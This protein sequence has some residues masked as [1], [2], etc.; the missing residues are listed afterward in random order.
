MLGLRQH[1]I[2]VVTACFLFAQAT[3]AR[4]QRAAENAI[5]A[6]Q[7]AFGTSVGNERIG[8]YSES[9]VRGFSPIAAGN[10]RIEGL[11][12]DRQTT[13]TARLIGGS[14]IR[15]GLTSQSY[16][17]TAPTGVVDYRLRPVG[18]E[19]NVSGYAAVGPHSGRQFDLDVQLPIAGDLLAVGLGATTLRQEPIPGDTS[20]ITSLAFLTRWTPSEN[21]E[22]RVALR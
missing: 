14:S 17:F 12:F 8:L 22:I 19:V 16:P 21:L 20:D 2:S 3:P 1:Y 9:D 7:D 11:Y 18:D 13:I 15:V 5:K 10:A 6:A 4:A